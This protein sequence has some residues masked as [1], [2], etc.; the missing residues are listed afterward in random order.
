M[1]ETIK[2]LFAAPSET[3]VTTA[4]PLGETAVA[5]NSMYTKAGLRPYNPDSLV[6]RKGLRV[7]DEMLI[8]D[9]IKFCLALKTR[10]VIAPGW[11]IEPVSDSAQDVEIAEFVEYALNQMVGTVDTA[12]HTVLSALKYGYSV[13]E[14]NWKVYDGGPYAGRVGIDS[15]KGKRP[16]G[17]AFDVDEY[18]NLRPDGLLQ[19]SLGRDEVRLPVD[20]FIIYSAQKEFS[21]HYGTSDLRS[22]YRAWWSKDNIIRFWNI[23]LERFGSP[24]AVGKYKTADPN[25]KNTLMTL[26][27]NLQNK[28]SIVHK[29]MDFDISLLEASRRS[30]SDYETSLNFHDRAIGRSILIPDRVFMAGEV[31]A[32]SQSQTHFDVFLWALD[33][34]RAEL[35]ETVMQEQLIWRLVDYNFPG[36]EEAPRFKFKPLTA[37]QRVSLATTFTEAVQ[38]GAVKSSFEDENHIREILDFPELSE[39]AYAERKEQDAAALEA[40]KAVAPAPEEKKKEFAAAPRSTTT[41]ERRVDFAQIEQEQDALEAKT[42]AAVR[43]VLERQLEALIAF[44][45]T[46]HRAGQLTPSFI[47][48][49]LTLKY[50]GEVK[51]ALT[52]MFEDAYKKAKKQSSQEL[53]KTFALKAQQGIAVAPAAALDYFGAKADFVVRGI[54]EPLITSTQKVLY[55]SLKTGEALPRTIK[56]LRDVYQPYL[57]DGAVIIDGK[58]ATAYRLE[59]IVRTNMSEAYAEGRKAYAADTD[60]YVVGYQFSEILDD[61]TTEISLFVDGKVIPANHPALPQL[62]YPLHYNDRG[63]FVLVTKDDAPVN[64]MSEGD[65]NKAISMA[66]DFA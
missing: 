31:G 65:I 50:M 7:Y 39:D 34:L 15:L 11:S 45:S 22:A 35:S 52:A 32:Y 24:I 49:G 42:V 20:K 56:K 58:Q 16:H 25:A 44:V 19:T 33:S 27:T 18:G 6:G 3:A 12:L 5:Y 53:G 26:L 4:P 36:V 55:N 60:G 64:Y 23:Y 10:G 57:A 40:A 1:I 29:D 47:N 21:N 30:T 9:Q 66:G 43:E 14:I 2:K 54:R 13:T 17:F 8:D 62:T 59:T 63:M 28:T 61:R 41:Y 38:K 51:T 48:T 37:A 46:K